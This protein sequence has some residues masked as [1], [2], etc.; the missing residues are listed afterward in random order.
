M[1]ALA[2]APAN[3]RSPDIL[4][5]TAPP[6][7]ATSDMPLTAIEPPPPSASN[8]PTDQAN[9]AAAEMSAEDQAAARR[10]R[11]DPTPQGE[12]QQAPEQPEAQ[13]DGDEAAP[14]EQA[15]T[16][17]GQQSDGEG[18]KGRDQT[19]PWMKREITKA[20]NQQRDAEL[21]ATA[22][23]A[24]RQRTLKLLEELSARIPEPTVAEPAAEPRPSRQQFDTPDAYDSALEAW[25]G[26]EGERR[27]TAENSRRAQEEKAATEQ[28]ARDDAANAQK[29]AAEAEITALQATWTEKRAKAVEKFPDYETVAEADDLKI[30]VPMA[31]SIMQAD[32]GP[33]IAYYLGQNP[34]EAARIAGI[35]N[36]G[37]QLFE[38]GKLA[39]KLTAPPVRT[40]RAPRP[41]SPL[42]GNSAPADTSAREPSMDEWAAKRTA[43]IRASRSPFMGTPT[44]Q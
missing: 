24:E 7:S 15:A 18:D 5:R 21:R 26:R 14:Q 27:A 33:D 2:V 36:V 10:A 16:D 17:E 28:K 43:E 13:A 19:P 38:M 42:N 12:Q 40:T 8:N 31:H 6:L 25:A 34:D 9:G 41:L 20:R 35:T 44:R 3:A 23:E 37:R 30:S 32:N 22:A 11:Q 39:A 4:V 29:A 1:T